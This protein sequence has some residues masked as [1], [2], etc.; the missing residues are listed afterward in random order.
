VN[1]F[2]NDVNYKY[3]W[4]SVYGPAFTDKYV[5]WWMNRISGRG[6]SPEFTCLLVRVLAYATQYPSASLQTMLE[7]ELACSSQALTERL[8]EAA[9]QLSCKFQTST[10]NLERVQEL[11]LRA[12]WL[13]SESRIVE[14]WHAIGTAIRAAQEL[15]TSSF[16]DAGL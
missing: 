16:N 14:S 10:P 15:G 11:F 3:N 1:H 5:E 13:K 12:A 9:E 2:L 6:L 8:G 4:S 7:F